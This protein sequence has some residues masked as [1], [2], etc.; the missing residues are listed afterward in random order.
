MIYLDN[1]A[2]TRVDEEVLRKTLPYLTDI[3][4]NA[5]SVHGAG[6]R[7]MKA[8]DDARERIAAQ[9]IARTCQTQAE[10]KRVHD[11][12]ETYYVRATDFAAVDAIRQS[13]EAE[14]FG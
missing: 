14:L 12:L 11:T 13:V 9:L 10:A 4:A 6:R 8:V 1:A 2:T 7:A 5:S 3:Y